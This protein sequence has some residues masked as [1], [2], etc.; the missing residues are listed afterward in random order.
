[1]TTEPITL[2]LAHA[3][4][5]MSDMF[6]SLVCLTFVKAL[7]YNVMAIFSKLM[8]HVTQPYPLDWKLTPSFQSVDE[9]HVAK[10]DHKLNILY[11]KERRYDGKAYEWRRVYMRINQAR[12]RR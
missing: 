4:R 3:R 8:S 10:Y 5:V 7:C 6:I 12:R 9:V 11:I 1:M 2:L